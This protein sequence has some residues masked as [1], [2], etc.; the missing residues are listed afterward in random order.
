[1]RRT[2][3]IGFLAVAGCSHVAGGPAS[4]GPA[5]VVDGHVDL[6]DRL[7]D[8][9]PITDA[10]LEE[11]A[12]GRS[13][14]DFD[15]ER[16]KRGGLNAPFMSIYVPAHHQVTGD[17]KAAADLR[18]D[19]VERLV[20]IAPDRFAIAR[21]PE[22]VRSIAASERVALPLGIENG[23]AV[24]DDLANVDYLYRRGVRYVT[25][26]HSKDNQI[27][28]SSYDDSRTWGGLSPF[29]EEV[30]RR[31]NAVGIMVDVSHVSEAVFWDVMELTDVPVIASHSSARHF[32]PGFE[33]NLSDDMIRRIGAEG[34]VVMIN[35]G[36]SFVSQ[37]SREYFQTRGQARAAFV[38]AN[39]VD[40]KHPDTQAFLSKWESEHP[41]VLASVSD[42]ADHIDHV[43][44][45][46]GIDHVGLGSDFDGVGPMLP[47]GLRSAADVPALF[48]ELRRRGY[49]DAALDRIAHQNIFRV[50]EAVQTAAAR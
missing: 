13:A 11:V 40:R 29:G 27:C 49:D 17:A 36:S 28:D 41:M 34:G 26:T 46:A 31:M 20:A 21:T 3:L 45:L 35:F 19:I 39:G 43:V 5:I 33:R 22:E 9:G 44:R 25:L 42:V 30:V 6:V 15:F 16:A 2:P 7:L 47:I 38:E 8:G 32:T 23:A 50:W 14:G 4:A 37:A 1:M 10:R 24:E 18:I 48:E 12:Y